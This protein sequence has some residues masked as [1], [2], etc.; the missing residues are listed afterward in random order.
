MTDNHRVAGSI[1]ANLRER[2]RKPPPRPA[3]SAIPFRGSEGG[4][5]SRS[6]NIP[7]TNHDTTMKFSKLLGRARLGNTHNLA[8]G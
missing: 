2:F 1:P 8:G 4:T 3:F 6:N 5:S 7:T